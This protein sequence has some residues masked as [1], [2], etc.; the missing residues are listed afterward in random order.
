MTGVNGTFKISPD[1]DFGDFGKEESD[2]FQEIDLDSASPEGL[3]G[4]QLRLEQPGALRT[5]DP[6]SPQFIPTDYNTEIR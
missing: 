2:E 1:F 6:A 5:N 4:R 3:Q